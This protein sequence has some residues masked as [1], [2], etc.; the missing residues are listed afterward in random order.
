MW[1][2]GLKGLRVTIINFLL[3]I[4]MHN[5]AEEVM[6]IIKMITYM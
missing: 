5:Q 4:A 2:L 3:T 6:R 1:I